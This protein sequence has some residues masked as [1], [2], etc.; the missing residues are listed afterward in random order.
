M[1]AVALGRQQGDRLPL[2]IS[3]G[4]L[5]GQLIRL[6]VASAQVKSC[7]LLAGLFADAPTTVVEPA[8]TR[9][10]TERMLRAQGARIEADGLS[11]TIWPVERLAPVDVDVPGD[12][13]SAAYWLTLACIHPDARVTVKNVGL[14]PLRTGLLDTLSEMGARIRID[15][16]HET[17]G[18]PVGDLT[19]ES[20]EL[21]GVE[22]GGERIPRMVDEVPLLAVAALFA[23]G[24]TTVRDAAE[25]RVKES[26]RLATTSRELQRLGGSVDE[27]DDGL[28]IRGGRRLVQGDVETHLDHRL[29]MCLAVAGLAGDGAVIGGAEVASVSY[30]RFWDDARALGG[31]IAS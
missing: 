29:A 20:S 21:R 7:L 19:A 12:F 28:L 9:D 30:P 10:H 16:L 24:D 22:V 31:A 8:P 14:N 25:L 18:E 17:G 11:R 2:A 13:S 5:H 1:G 6:T 15:N 26:D 27:R 3:G 23:R 4:A